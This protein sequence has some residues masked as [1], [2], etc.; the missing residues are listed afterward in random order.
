[1]ACWFEESK[2][3]NTS[4]NPKNY[5]LIGISILMHNYNAKIFKKNV[6]VSGKEPKTS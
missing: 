5:S 6:H 4:I 3:K 2:H 1:M